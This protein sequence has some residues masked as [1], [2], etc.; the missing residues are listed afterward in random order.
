MNAPPA[1]ASQLTLYLSGVSPLPEFF[2]RLLARADA[3]PAPS[4]QGIDRQLALFGIDPQ[5]DQD[6]PVAAITRVADFG[7]I[8]NDWWIRADPVYLAAQRDGL[9]LH[10]APG[11]SAAESER[12]TAELNESLMPEGLLLKS[13]PAGRWY[14][15]PARAPRISTTPLSAAA[16]RNVHALLPQGED[17]QLWHARLNELQILL[18]TS[19][20]NAD[21]EARGLL[22][23]NSVWFWGG[24][25]LPRIGKTPWTTIWADDPLTIGLARLIECPVRAPKNFSPST[26]HSERELMVLDIQSGDSGTTEALHAVVAALHNG[27]CRSLTVLR[28]SGPGYRCWRWQRWRFW[29]RPE[30]APPAE[31]AL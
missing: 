20:V 1:P 2:A 25:R 30:T 7:V 9:I 12:L 29:R 27:S 11:L 8:D 23:A 18:H 3:L 19:P 14:L 22:P 21:R 10:P 28:E 5:P 6:A 4:A 13:A 24:G 31:V 26:S 16:G 17:R 15:K